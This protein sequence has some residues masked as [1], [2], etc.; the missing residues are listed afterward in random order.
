MHDRGATDDEITFISIAMNIE[1]E[2]R[3]KVAEFD[4]EE[5]VT[6]TG[7][8]TDVGEVIGYAV[9]VESIA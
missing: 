9:D 7:T 6:V 4:D 2:H 8:I 1:D 5:I 3:A